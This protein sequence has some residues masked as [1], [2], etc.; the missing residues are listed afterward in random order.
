MR[1]HIVMPAVGSRNIAWAQ[2]SGV[3]HSE[4]ALQPLDLSNGLFRFHSSPII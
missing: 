2:R 4:D 1:E 3:G